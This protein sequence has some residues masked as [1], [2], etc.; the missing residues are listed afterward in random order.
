M[1]RLVFRYNNINLF[2][3]YNTILLFIKSNNC[4]TWSL[5]GPRHLFHLFCRTTRYIFELL[6]V[7]EPSFNM[8]MSYI[9]KV[10]PYLDI[11]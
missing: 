6:H 2:L 1:K 8:D 11:F 4:G 7:Y 3:M 5:N 9:W 10:R